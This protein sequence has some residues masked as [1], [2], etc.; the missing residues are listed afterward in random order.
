MSGDPTAR[1]VRSGTLS[2]QVRQPN[3]MLSRTRCSHGVL[4]LTHRLHVPRRTFD[5]WSE[6][7]REDTRAAKKSITQGFF[8]FTHELPSVALKRLQNASCLLRGEARL[9]SRKEQT[10]AVWSCRRDRSVRSSLRL[11]GG[12]KAPTQSLRPLR[13][14]RRRRATLRL[15]RTSLSPAPRPAHQCHANVQIPEWRRAWCWGSC[16]AR[17]FRG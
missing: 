4:S 10:G 2:R 5:G 6:C 15:R 13:A 1:I 12:A 14:G 9:G 7:A 3:C 17:R 16:R 11:R 8:I